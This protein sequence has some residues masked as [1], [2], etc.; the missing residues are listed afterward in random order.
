MKRT[1]KILRVTAF[2]FG[3]AVVLGL[4][5]FVGSIRSSAS[6]DEVLINILGQTKEKMVE[7]L[8]VRSLI[9]R[10]MGAL[11]G[12]PLNKINTREIETLLRA[13]PHIKSAR[14]YETID[15]RLI[16]E[17]H[18]RVPL[19]RLFDKDG[20]TALMD[21]QGNIMPLSD[22]VVLR[23]PVITGQF[24]ISKNFVGA[25]SSLASAKRDSSLTQIFHY[26]RAIASDSFWKAQIQQT[27]VTS[28]G[29]FLV[30]PQVGNN[31]INFGSADRIEEKLNRLR[32]FYKESPVKTGWNKYSN[33]NLKFKDQIVCTKK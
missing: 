8:D 30:Y 4:L 10:D 28:V 9:S 17:L 7:E 1:S 15:K 23:I 24:S 20:N 3:A 16:I 12:M 2:V 5:G 19:V 14:V 18:E 33:I 29:D 27:E 26:A 21:S 11:V 13:M 22:H 31:T 32:I 6:C 25:D